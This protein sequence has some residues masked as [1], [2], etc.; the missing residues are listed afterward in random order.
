MTAPKQ[1]QAQTNPQVEAPVVETKTEE[2]STEATVET[3]PVVEQSEVEK[4]LLARIADLEAVIA[5]SEKQVV[6]NSTPVVNTVSVKP[7][8]TQTLSD[9][10]KVTHN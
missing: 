10:T 9:G 2:T 4:A 7:K 6:A 3:T 1:K 8:S 5:A